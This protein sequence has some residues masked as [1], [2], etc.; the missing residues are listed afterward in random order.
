MRR[1]L[2]TSNRHQQVWRKPNG[3]LK[4]KNLEATMKHGGDSLIVWESTSATK[5]IYFIEGI[6]ACIEIKFKTVLRN[7]G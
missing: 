5:N 1:N 4:E 3:Q 2:S 7:L 6:N